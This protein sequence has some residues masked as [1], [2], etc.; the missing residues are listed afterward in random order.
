M[1]NNDNS[2]QRRLQLKPKKPR[3]SSD[4]THIVE[5][6]VHGKN[7][8]LASYPVVVVFNVFRALL[9]HFILIVKALYRFGCYIARPHS[10]SAGAQLVEVT[11]D[12]A[13]TEMAAVR[14]AQPGPGDPILA[15]QKHHHRKAFEYISKALKIDEEHEGNLSY[16]SDL[17]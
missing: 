2:S 9:Y 10:T 5:S 16:F 15:K 11:G 3:R 8:Y 4:K 6:S 1:S 17:F 7:F 12:Q 14:P 13:C